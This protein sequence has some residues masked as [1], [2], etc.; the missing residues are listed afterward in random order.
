MIRELEEKGIGRP[1]TYATIISTIQDRQYVEKE[2]ARF[3]P[4]ELGRTVN[5]R[6]V[7]HFPGVF[8][9]EFTAKMENEL[10]NI[11]EGDKDWVTIVKD[12]YSPFVKD[13]NVAEDQME[14][15]KGKEEPTDIVC[16]KCG[17]E[18][19]D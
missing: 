18:Y 1:S 7:R 10:D 15:L 4:T 14:G 2:E 16:E 5:D 19:G 3:R 8:D 9:I 11:E 13:L 12:F 17:R 6:L